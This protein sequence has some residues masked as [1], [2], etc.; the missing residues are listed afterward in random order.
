VDHLR[1]RHPPA[2]GGATDRSRRGVPSAVRNGRLELFLSPD[3]LAEVRN[4][5]SRP[6]TLTETGQSDPK[7]YGDRAQ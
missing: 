5:L 2:G 4:A 3:I 6:K 1:L 7:L